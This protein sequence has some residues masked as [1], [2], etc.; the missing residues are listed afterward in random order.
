MGRLQVYGLPPRKTCR[1]E[2]CG[3]QGLLSQYEGH[4]CERCAEMC[5]GKF[6]CRAVKVDE[7]A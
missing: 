6:C 3:W 2:E 4:A 7:E 1:C 5:G